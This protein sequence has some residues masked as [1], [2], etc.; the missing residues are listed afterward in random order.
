[1]LVMKFG[2]AS[3]KT[4]RSFLKIAKII[5]ERSLCEKKIVVVVSAMGNTTDK[6]LE[7]ARKVHPNPP[8]R[9]QDMLV[10]VG[11]RISISL[12]SMALANVGIDAV[13]FTGSQSGVITCENHTDA[14]IVDVKPKRLVE[15][16]NLG[17]IAI[18]AGFQGVSR[19]GEITT[20]GRG[21]SDTSAVALAVA[22]DAPVVE[23]YKDVP[24]IF[25]ADPKKDPKAKVF[26][27]LSYA[28]ALQ[29]SKQ[30]AKVLH[31]RSIELA[32]KNGVQLSVR[33]FQNPKGAGTLVGSESTRNPCLSYEVPLCSLS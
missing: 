27:Q 11:E 9:E 26:S 2:G 30:G 28:D 6:L 19:K 15:A 21:G 13:S 22:L 14:R 5:K 33:S 31:S 32:E 29:L 25:E 10:S 7:L 24:G 4:T 8:S 18:V 1:M 17:R 12:L 16:L 23:F 3:V 20:L